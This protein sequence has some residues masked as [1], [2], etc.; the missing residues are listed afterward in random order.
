MMTGRIGDSVSAPGDVQIGTDQYQ[1][2]LVQ[3]ATVRV[4]EHQ[5]V[6]RHADGGGLVDQLLGIGVIA[7][8][9]QREAGPEVVE[10]RDGPG[11]RRCWAPGDPRAR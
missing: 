5:V 2:V 10:Q 7:C 4:F 6:Q 11:R 1:P 9:D 8:V 3:R